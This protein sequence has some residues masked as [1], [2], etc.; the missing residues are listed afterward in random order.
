[1]DGLTAIKHWIGP[2]VVL[3]ASL[4]SHPA[5]RAEFPQP[6]S[7]RDAA[8][9]QRDWTTTAA[10]FSTFQSED[11]ATADASI[12]ARSYESSRIELAQ[13]VAG[14]SDDH[15]QLAPVGL[16]YKSYLAGA[17]EARISTVWM[18]DSKRGLIWENALGGRVGVVRYGTE[19]VLH[20]E[21]WQFDI[22]GAALPRV[23]PQDPSSP[24]E[25]VDFRVGLL[26]TWRYG[27]TAVKAG[28]YHLSSHAGDEFL[29]NNPAFV[30]INYVRDAGIIGITQYFLE[31]FSVYGELAYAFNAEDGAEPLE[32]Q[33]G[34]QYS[35]MTTG[36]PGAPF[37]AINGHTRED[38]NWATS[39][40][41][42]SGW[43]WR[44]AKTNHT[45]RVGMQYYRGPSLQ[46]E[47]GDRKE[48]MLGG[49]IWYDF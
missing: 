12:P 20:P 41:V 3:T 48:N 4:A 34:V 39:L 9:Q 35:P 5:A 30:R 40:T 7:G 29:I 22:E 36:W 2:L 47:L 31:D 33:Y 6:A 21:G 18:Q 15:W 43:Q 38:Y 14:N 10:G 27:D 28:Y 19:D 45:F 37:A 24:L 26:S 44:S 11:V 1:M 17:K 42:Q 46:W 23:I 32:F 25:A 49:G 8:A 16:L 13:A